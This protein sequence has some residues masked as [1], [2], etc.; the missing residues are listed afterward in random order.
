MIVNDAI[1]SLV[2]VMMCGCGGGGDQPRVVAEKPIVLEVRARADLV[3]QGVHVEQA[4]RVG[5]RVSLRTEFKKPF[6]GTVWIFLLDEKGLELGR[7]R[8][9]VA[10]ESGPATL[11]FSIGVLSKARIVEVATR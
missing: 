8:T 3:E 7:A 10:R 4:T 2:I 6:K 9:E 1:R 5:E 11:E